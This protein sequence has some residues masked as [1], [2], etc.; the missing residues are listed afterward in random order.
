MAETFRGSGYTEKVTTAPMTLYRTYTEGQFPLGQFWSR[1]RPHG[2]MQARIDS[3]LNPEWGNEATAISAI[4]V[5]AGVR[6]FEGAV[7]PQDIYG[8]GVLLGG[9]NQIV[10]EPDFFVPMDWLR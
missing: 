8:G 1:D 9:G 7:A 4:E 10:F 5:P 2:P 3:A 6:F